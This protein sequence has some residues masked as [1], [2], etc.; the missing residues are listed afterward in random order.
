MSNAYVIQ[1][2]SMVNG[3]AGKGTKFFDRAEAEE[4]AE[5]LNREYPQIRHE[6]VKT[7]L[8]QELEESPQTG[9]RELSF[10]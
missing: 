4:L 2:K 6:A 5:E 8:E 10:R 9:V 3:R 7:G 1:W